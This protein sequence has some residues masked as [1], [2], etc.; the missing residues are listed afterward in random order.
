MNIISVIIVASVFVIGFGS[1][2]VFQLKNNL[3]VLEE[4]HSGLDRIVKLSAES[5]AAAEECINA[6]RQENL[7]LKTQL[8][9]Y[10]TRR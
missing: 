1:G 7:E 8:N 10:K 2:Y 5:D 6:L 9:Y 3:A 4:L